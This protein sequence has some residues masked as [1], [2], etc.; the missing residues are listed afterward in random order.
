MIWDSFSIFRTN[1]A[2]LTSYIRAD[3]NLRTCRWLSRGCCHV[4]WSKWWVWRESLEDFSQRWQGIRQ[5]IR[6]TALTCSCMPLANR[7]GEF[8]QGRKQLHDGCEWIWSARTVKLNV[9]AFAFV[10]KKL[11]LLWYRVNLRVSQ[12]MLNH[13][14]NLILMV[15]HCSVC[16]HWR[17]CKSF[18]AAH[19]HSAARALSSPNRCFQLSTNFDKD[20]IR[21]LL[22]WDAATISSIAER[23]LTW[24]HLS[25][26]LI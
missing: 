1:C 26:S 18:W 13:N 15:G 6:S 21:C 19:L 22:Y 3:I 14:Q 10:L 5:G 20:F 25:V 4:A 16:L 2:I 7:K 9:L 8:F 23:L 12:T 24:C 17:V 11:C